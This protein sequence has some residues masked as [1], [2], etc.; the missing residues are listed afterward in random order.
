MTLQPGH[1]K[2]TNRDWTAEGST[3][4]GVKCEQLFDFNVGCANSICW[5]PDGK[6]M[7]FTDSGDKQLL[8]FDYDTET[9]KPSNKRVFVDFAERGYEGI[10]DGATTD[11]AGGVWVANFGGGRVLRFDP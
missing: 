4:F 7:Y 9:G 8:A 3:N 1:G 11:T 2:Q 10:A 5:S 6:T